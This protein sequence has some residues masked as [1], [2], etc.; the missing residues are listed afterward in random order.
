MPDQSVEDSSPGIL[1]L[2]WLAPLLFTSGACSLIYQVAWQRELGLIFGNST[3]ASAAVIAVFIA[4]LGAGSLWLGRRAERHRRPVQLYGRLEA[5]VALLVPLSPLLLW[6]VGKLYVALGGTAALGSIFGNV[7]RLLLTALV[8]GAPT[9]L[10]GGTL[11][12]AVR[13][14]MSSQDRG[15]GAVGYLYAINTLGAVT[16]AL[17]ATFYLLEA[18]GTRGTLFYASAV[19]LLV[20]LAAIALGARA[21]DLPAA[22]PAGADEAGAPA[23][24]RERPAPV[25]GTRRGHKDGASGR[26]GQAGSTA[27][28]REAAQGETGAP[29]PMW[30]SLGAAAVTG[31]SFFLLEIVWYRMLGPILGGSVFAFG[32]ILATALLGIGLGGAL[33]ALVWRHRRVSVAAFATTSLL[34]AAAVALPLALGDDVALLALVLRELGNLG[35]GPLVGGWMLAAGVVVLPASILSG[36]QFPALISLL[37]EGPRDVARHIGLTYA[38]NTV[39]AAAGALAGGFGLIVL[40]G[41]PG[42]WRLC[43][44]LYA[45]V[46]VAA[47]LVAIARERRWLALAAPV[48][49]GVVTVMLVGA[50]GPTAVWRHGGIGAGRSGLSGVPS[51]ESWRDWSNETRRQLRW[52]ADGVESSIA[53]SVANDL[54]FEVNGKFDGSAVSDAGTQVMGGLV[55]A[56]FHPDAGSALVIGLG[57]GSTAGW[58]GAVSSIQR[59]DVVEL[60][61]Q[62][63]RVARDFALVNR[64]VLANPKVVVTIGDARE[65]L[66][67]SRKTYDI[68]FSEPSNPYRAGV[69]S[70][71]TREFYQMG[72]EHLGQGGIFLQWVQSY[73]VDAKTLRTV[74]ATIGSVFPAVEVWETREGD[75]LLVASRAPLA[76]T[77]AKLRARIAEEPFRSALAKTWHVADL[78]GFVAHL[79]AGPGLVGSVVRAEADALNTDDRMLIEFGF[80]RSVGHTTARRG[81]L[82]QAASRLGA[83]RQ[84]ELGE[85][86]DWDRIEEHRAAIPTLSAAAP[87]LPSSI[88]LAAQL[89]LV[90]QASWTKADF[91]GALQAWTSQDGEPRSFI[92]LVVLG[93]ALAAAGDDRARVVIEKLRPAFAAEADVILAHLLLRQG[94]LEEATQAVVSAYG[95]YRSDPWPFAPLMRA[96]LGRAVEIASAGS[97]P[98]AGPQAG[99]AGAGRVERLFRALQAPFA[100]SMLDSARTETLLSLARTAPDARLCVEALTPYEPHVVWRRPFLELR[101]A[102]YLRRG[103][104]LGARADAD[105]REFMA[106]QAPPFGNGLESLVRQEAR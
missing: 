76:R 16:G 8:L 89:R 31:F 3:A 18:A 104:A 87:A 52:E 6:L 101:S 60:E 65:V 17:L 22:Q 93:D 55:G 44:V 99:D 67:T 80:A 96:G 64:D 24:P 88:S 70:L 25:Q 27:A 15:R 84:I 81:E 21:G 51:R 77:A 45:L 59:V 38:W 91:G 34:E 72:A 48:A 26:G 11:P 28:P 86:L 103:H 14:V 57:T 71:F 75:L 61:P 41:A 36:L 82:I 85:A 105:L 73:E 1:R 46:G 63:L 5:S 33:Y 30:L 39:G 66:A 2:R 68:I 50:Q 37:G 32:T 95:R 90:A 100:A 98:A 43:A 4:G 94:R 13:S 19:N 79:V 53:I 47:L 83:L 74:F 97:P 40:V 10:L 92:E 106:A 20:G 78:E 7:L 62:V 69:A 23:P 29:P 12:A 56:L 35:F 9:F 54:N 49:L 42:V 58:L 102:C